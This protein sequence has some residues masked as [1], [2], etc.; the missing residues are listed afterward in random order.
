MAAS[1][2]A[3]MIAFFQKNTFLAGY[4]NISSTAS[5][6]VRKNHLEVIFNKLFRKI[7]HVLE[8]STCYK[9]IF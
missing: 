1:R 4:M 5:K 7:S 2:I 9:V 3:C 6:A 8:E